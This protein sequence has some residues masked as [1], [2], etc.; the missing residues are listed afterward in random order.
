MLLWHATQRVGAALRADSDRRRRAIFEDGDL[1]GADHQAPAFLAV[2]ADSTFLPAWHGHSDDIEVYVG[3]AYSGKTERLGRPALAEKG[4]CSDL[5][6]SAHFGQTLLTM[7]QTRHNA[8]D[9]PCG[10][11]LSDGAACLRTIQEDHF[12]RLTRQL[13]WAHVL[14]RVLEAYGPAHSDRAHDIIA[15]LR[16]GDRQHACEYVSAHARRWRKR[17]PYLRELRGYLDGPGSDLYGIRC[18][19]AAGIAVPP[20][21][22]GTGGIERE[23]GV[24]VGQRMKRR[25]MTWTRRGAENLLAVRQQLL[26][27]LSVA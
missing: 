23:I 20:R 8:L 26:D 14:R 10:A 13:D 2:E 15:S 25:G 1:P 3:I 21:M 12:P 22:E 18:L 16:T 7:A 4:R 27:R 11:F 5:R 9:S 17:A 24:F 19:R 6:G